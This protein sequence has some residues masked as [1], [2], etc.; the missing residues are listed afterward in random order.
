MNYRSILLAALQTIGLFFTGFVI[1]LLGQVI[2]LF[3]PVPLILSYVRDGRREGVS[4]LLFASAVIAAI[5]GWQAAAILFF[6]FGLMAL[7]IGEGMRRNLKPEQTALIGGFLPIAVLMLMVIFYIARPGKGP[8]LV[9]EEYLR[10]SIVEAAKLY[11]IVVFGKQAENCGQYLNKGDAALIEGRL[12]QRRWD[13][14]ETGQKRSKVE[15]AAQQV[16]FMPKRSSTAAGHGR[17]QSPSE[18]APEASVDE[19]EIPF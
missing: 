13:D 4:A 18:P 6:S 11:N 12:Q 9:A 1:P 15:V 10:N 8:I 14:K 17:D 2:A 19:G 7:G 16:T 3:A 5:G